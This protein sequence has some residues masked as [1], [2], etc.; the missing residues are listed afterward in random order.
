M[1]YILY[2]HLP[3]NK[4][5]LYA[6]RLVLFR[7]KFVSQVPFPAN[8]TESQRP[9]GKKRKFWGDGMLSSNVDMGVAFVRGTSQKAD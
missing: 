8:R 5:C 3:R 7:L 2:G 1:G 4:Y 9:A 6:P